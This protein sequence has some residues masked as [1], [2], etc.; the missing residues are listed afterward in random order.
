MNTIR[1]VGL[2]PSSCVNCRRRKIKLECDKPTSRSCRRCERLR[3]DCVVTDEATIR[4]YYHISEEQF[5]LMAAIVRHYAPGISSGVE[6]LRTFVSTLQ[7][8]PQA[9]EF[10]I[11]LAE[12]VPPTNM[13]CSQI[14][15]GHLLPTVT[16]KDSASPLSEGSFIPD[17]TRQRS[18]IQRCLKLCRASSKVSLCITRSF[19]RLAALQPSGTFDLR[20]GEPLSRKP[21]AAL[22]DRKTCHDP[23]HRA[24]IDDDA[25]HFELASKKMESVIAEGS[26]E[27]IQ[28]IIIMVSNNAVLP[29]F[30]D[31]SPLWAEQKTKLWWSLCDLDQWFTSVLGRSLGITVDLSNID[32]SSDN[33][34]GAPN[35][36]PMYAF[37]SARLTRL[38]SRTLHCNSEKRHD[39]GKEI[40]QLTQDLY[41]WWNSLPQH[42][43]IPAAAI[44]ASLVRS[45]LYL[46]L[47][48][49]CI[50]VLLTQSYLFNAT[51][52]GSE[53]NPR[54]NICE[55]S[56]DETIAILVEMH[57]RDVLTNHFW[58]D[59]Y[60]AVTCGLVLLIRIIKNPASVDLRDKC[61]DKVLEDIEHHQR[62]VRLS[63]ILIIDA[64]NLGK[65][66]VAIIELPFR[67]RNGIHGSWVPRSHMLHDKDVCDMIGITT[68]I[69]QKFEG[70]AVQPASR[71]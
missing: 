16:A 10:P 60:H 14:V 22:P 19:P 20:D 28:A 49:H 66:P 65:G 62:D 54:M 52:S 15:G 1:R 4:P 40:D 33:L 32:S 45:T 61:F 48:Y 70:I 44:P 63:C 13:S 7:A 5:E 30:T 21:D 43:T 71:K 37:A 8:A 68:E 2:L 17:A 42:L 58:F 12:P 67:L 6:D 34:I 11:E 39:N 29:Y 59:S 3:L 46:R 18:K 31:Q 50:I 69:R 38:L 47:R 56:N 27:S 36:P 24:L 53:A 41:G 57:E 9:P 64:E 23:S 26:I 25:H 51:F 55:E 35:M